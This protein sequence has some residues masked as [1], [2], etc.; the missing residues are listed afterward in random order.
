M[1]EPERLKKGKDFEKEVV[2]DFRKHSEDGFVSSNDTIQ[3]SKLR[4]DHGKRGR[5]DILI[6]ELG[7]FVTILEIKCTD[8]DRIKLKNCMPSAPMGQ[9]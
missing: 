9:I 1:T 7:D 6:T 5:P 4:A 3:L 2:A 8:W